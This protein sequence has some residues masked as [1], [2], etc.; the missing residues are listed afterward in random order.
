MFG[1][2]SLPMK[3]FVNR[4]KSGYLVLIVSPWP[5]LQNY[6]SGRLR[7]YFMDLNMLTLFNARERTLQEFVELG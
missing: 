3:L 4:H 7:D 5:L 1:S 6:G 2:M